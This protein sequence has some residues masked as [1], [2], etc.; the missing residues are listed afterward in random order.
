VGTVTAAIGMKAAVEQIKSLCR[1]EPVE[2]ICTRGNRVY[3]IFKT[4]EN[5]L[6]VNDDDVYRICTI[7]RP[8]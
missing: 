5:Y 2:E 7:G 1:D 3:I 6:T 4:G 8:W